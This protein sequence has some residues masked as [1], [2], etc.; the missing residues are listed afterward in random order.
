MQPIRNAQVVLAVGL[1]L[2]ALAAAV[3]L[4]LGAPTVLAGT[5]GVA[6]RL[7]PPLMVMP[8][9]GRA[10][11]ADETLPA[12]ASAVRISLEASAGPRVAVVVLSGSTPV[13]HGLSATGWLGRV[14]TVPIEPLDRT[15]RHATVCFS[16]AGAHERVSLL[17]AHT[18]APK[19]ARSDARVLAGRVAIEYLRSGSSSWWSLAKSVARRMGLGRAWAGTWIAFLIAALMATAIV[20]GSWLTVRECR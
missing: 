9:A 10:C 4:L 13:A 7:Y 11:Q 18:P 5:N 15:I 6:A 14:V 3:V 17:G 16:F 8:G 2:T 12:G 19:A 20:L 1:A